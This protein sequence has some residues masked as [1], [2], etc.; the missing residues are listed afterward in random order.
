M[1]I[2]YMHILGGQTI[3]SNNWSK[4]PIT[5]YDHRYWQSTTWL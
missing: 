1:K 2:E 5:I 3:D 4:T